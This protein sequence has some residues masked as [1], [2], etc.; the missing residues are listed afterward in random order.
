MSKLDDILVELQ[1]YIVAVE[2]GGNPPVG[3]QTKQQIKDLVVF[4]IGKTRSFEDNTGRVWVDPEQLEE[5]IKK[6]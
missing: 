2:R 5:R 4:L 3:E 6:L 1:R